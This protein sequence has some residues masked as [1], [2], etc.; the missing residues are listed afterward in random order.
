[1]LQ[2][3]SIWLPKIHIK[4]LLRCSVICS[5]Y[6]LA[7]KHEILFVLEVNDGIIR[8]EDFVILHPG[9][10]PIQDGERMAYAR[11]SGIGSKF[12]D[13]L[14]N[15]DVL[16]G[17]NGASWF[18]IF[19]FLCCIFSVFYLTYVSFLLCSFLFV[20]VYLQIF[21]GVPFRMAKFGGVRLTCI[22]AHLFSLLPTLFVQFFC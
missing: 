9:Q 7:K 16:L 8:L 1:M 15:N 18:A 12:N 22:K 20:L 21:C 17:W 11:V 19:S 14:G 2:G 13:E 6:F 3:I 5:K 10:E 4:V